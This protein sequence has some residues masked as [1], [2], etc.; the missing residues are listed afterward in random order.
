MKKLLGFIILVLFIIF[1]YLYV[2][3]IN[4]RQEEKIDFLTTIED[5]YAS[6]TDYYIYGNH[7]NIEGIIDIDNIEPDNFY[8]VLKN[9]AEEINI[10]CQFYNEDNKIK[11]KTSK[12]IN[13][14]INLDK[15]KKGKY[16]LLIKNEE[17]YYSLINDTEYTELEYYTITKNKSNNKINLDFK[18]KNINDKNIKYTNITIKNSKLPNDIYDITIDPGHGGV[19]TGASYKYNGK[20]YYESNLVLDIALKLKKQLESEGYKVLLTR[21]S[22]KNLDYYN[23]SGRATL[24]NKYHTKLCISLH[25]NKEGI[26]MN[27]GG[28]EVYTPNDVDYSLSRL[29]ASNIS[30]VNGYSKKN[31]NKIEDG[32]YFNGYTEESIKNNNDDY[33]RQGL[34]TYEIKIGTP[35][36]YMIREVGG[37]LTY[38]YVDGRNDK[39]GKNP[40]Y[41]SNQVAESYLI[42]LGYINYKDDIDKF[43]NNGES[44]S[45]AIF[46]AINEY[47]Q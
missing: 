26:Q 12:L 35:E 47:C 16:Y 21:D 43:I 9:D 29:L 14:G 15:L 41:N 36:M 18:E 11:F 27:Y 45:S 7:L 10:N 5:K 8:L 6:I 23:E 39:Y 1:C 32:I 3:K 31:H 20:E 46:N 37:K 2:N 22:D 44:F 19:D 38:A 34:K 40:Y 30:N 17:K 13:Q 42:E 4:T 33:I 24:P 28:V 25:L